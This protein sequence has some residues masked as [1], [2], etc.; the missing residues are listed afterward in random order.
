MWKLIFLI[1]FPPI[2]AHNACLHLIKISSLT[3]LAQV[4]L[5]QSPILLTHRNLHDKALHVPC[6]YGT[7]FEP[8]PVEL[9]KF[10]LA[11]QSLWIASKPRLEVYTDV[12]EAQISLLTNIHRSFDIVLKGKLYPTLSLKF[13]TLSVT[14]FDIWPHHYYTPM[15]LLGTDVSLFNVLSR[16]LEFSFNL[17][18][19][20]LSVNGR[21][22]PNGTL[23]G[24][25]PDVSI[26]RL[27]KYWNKEMFHGEN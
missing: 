3:D 2:W 6:V 5:S 7:I 11:F 17:L 19:R 26:L 25:L 18:P 13:R 8:S 9:N 21:V 10:L 24:I 15:G 27:G 14:T 22:L 1:L 23:V 12:S 20:A 16:K 4:D